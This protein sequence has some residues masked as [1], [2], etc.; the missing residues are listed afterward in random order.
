MRGYSQR[1]WFSQASAPHLPAGIFSP[2]GR[3]E[4][5]RGAGCVFFGSEAVSSA[6]PDP[7]RVRPFLFVGGGVCTRCRASSGCRHL[8]TPAGRRNLWHGFHAHRN[9]A[10]GTSPLPACGERARV[11]GCSQ[12]SWFS[13]ASAPHLPAGI[14]SPFG[15]GEETRGAGCVFFRSEAVSSALPDPDRVR[16]FLLVGGGVCTR[17]CPSSG[18]RHLSTPA[19]R[20][21]VWHGFHAHRNAAS[22]TSPLPACGERA[23]VR[24]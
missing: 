24:G 13:R 14:F 8:S 7:D 23:R 17:C 20:R 22:G 2:F 9:A 12:R 4:E 15:R 1:S 16:P 18:C 5:T 19:G 11:R 21:N 6:L 3:V 10:S